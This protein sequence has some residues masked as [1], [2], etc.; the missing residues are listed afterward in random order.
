MDR[1]NND[2]RYCASNIA[3]GLPTFLYGDTRAA[4]HNIDKVCF[5]C[6]F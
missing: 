1:S 6:L 2:M 4:A 5:K 3:A